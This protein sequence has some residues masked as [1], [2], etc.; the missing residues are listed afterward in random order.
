MIS[1]LESGLAVKSAEGGRPHNSVRGIEA[2]VVMLKARRSMG[3]TQIATALDLPK[4]SAHDLVAGLCELGFVERHGET[5]RY[6]VS[7]RIFGFLHLCSTEY[8]ANPALKPLLREEAAKLRASVVVTALRGR[9]TYALC[10]SGPETDTFLVGDHGPAYS[11]AC[12]RV[13]ISQFD[14]AAWADYAPRPDDK[15]K[16]PYCR[17]D[18]DHFFQQLRTARECGTAWSLREREPNLC[19]VAAPIRSWEQP[20]SRAVGI[21]LNHRE[22]ALRDRE[23]LAGQA[24]ALAERIARLM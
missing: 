23:E 6:S 8:G 21:I 24:R 22:C 3:I 20:C 1:T 19:S 9:T 10:G 16:S 12:G 15:P 5:R 14:E 17:V 13:L 18:R 7:P 11:S 4:S 2:L